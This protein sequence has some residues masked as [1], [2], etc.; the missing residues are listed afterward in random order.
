SL[1]GTRFNAAR[2][3]QEVSVG[4]G[5]MNVLHA[6]TISV[7]RGP[8]TLRVGSTAGADDFVAETQLGTGHHSIAFIPTGNFHVE[9]SSRTQYAAL[10]DSIQVAS[11][12]VMALPAPWAEEDLGNLRCDQSVDVLFIDC[13]GYPPRRLERRDNDS[14]SIVRYQPLN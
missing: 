10:V 9:L 1:V 4:G 12:G 14:W 3:R 2:R 7:N 8:V 5:D 11:G 13:E 6:L